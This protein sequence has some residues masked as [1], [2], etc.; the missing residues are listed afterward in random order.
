MGFTSCASIGRLCVLHCSIDQLFF[1]IINGSSSFYANETCVPYPVIIIGLGDIENFH[2]DNCNKR[3][4]DYC[5]NIALECHNKR[6]R[7]HP[8]CVLVKI[9]QASSE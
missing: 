4:C 2:C 9:V 7:H 1:Y 6:I 8:T 3:Q 5:G